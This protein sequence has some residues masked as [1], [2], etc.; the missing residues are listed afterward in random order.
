MIVETAKAI[1]RKY[2]Q[3]QVDKA[4]VDYF[5]GHLTAVSSQIHDNELAKA[6]AYLH[7]IIED[8]DIAPKQLESELMAG[9]ITELQALTI[10]RVVQLL[11]KPDVDYFAYLETVKA[12]SLAKIVKLADLTH[13]M[14]RSRLNSVSEKD[15]M[16][17]AKYAKAYAFLTD[18]HNNP[19]PTP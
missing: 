11:T 7:D 9:G 4:D 10:S 16:R 8:C 19:Q 3:G 6:I 17:L 15:E 18:R 2:H 5:S 14:D 13:N 1:A 12:D